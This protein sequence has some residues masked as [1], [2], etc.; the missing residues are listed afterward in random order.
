V[1]R[2][3]AFLA[4]ILAGVAIAQEDPTAQCLERLDQ[5][6][7]LAP[8]LPRIGSAMDGQRVTLEMQAS[9]ERISEAEKPIL[10][11][12]A[13][14]RRDCVQLG[15]GFRTERAPSDFAAAF[16]AGQSRLLDLMSDLYAG[17][18]TWGEFVTK[19]RHLSEQ[20]GRELGTILAKTRERAAVQ[21]QEASRV[22]APV[23]MPV[24]P[25]FQPIPMPRLEWPR[26]QP[27]SPPTVQC[28]TER[29]LNQLQTTCR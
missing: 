28:T 19:R 3:I 9:T 26:V 14:G 5:D 1:K 29:V 11:M 22:A 7:R 21:A 8:I 6:S 2:S 27:A 20:M 24:R 15:E 4:M 12:W 25:Q 18:L 17:G 13:A 16:S 10:S 23:P